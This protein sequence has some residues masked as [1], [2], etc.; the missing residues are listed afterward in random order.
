MFPLGGEERRVKGNEMYGVE[1]SA[2]KN[3]IYT[4]EEPRRKRTSVYSEHEGQPLAE[5]F[6]A[7]SS[8]TPASSPLSL[9]S[10]RFNASPSPTNFNCVRLDLFYRDPAEVDRCAAISLA[11]TIIPIAHGD[12]SD[13]WARCQQRRARLHTNKLRRRN[14][15]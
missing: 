4:P 2:F 6:T 1:V 13:P 3:L 14:N 11:L 9:T 10:T 5:A 12:Y 7:P 15:I 8:S